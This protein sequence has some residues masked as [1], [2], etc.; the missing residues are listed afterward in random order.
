MKTNIAALMTFISEEEKNL[1][2][3]IYSIKSYIFNTTIQELDG[4]ENV[5]EDN[6]SNFDLL[7]NDIELITKKLSTLKS[8]LYDK[9]N[10]FKLSDG[11]TIQQAIVENTNLRKLKQCY[12]NL[13]EY[14]NTKKRVSEV[15]NSYFECKFINFNQDEIR[16]KLKELDLSIQNTDFEISKLNSKEFEINI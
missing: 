6:K 11:R 5:I 3:S 9:N 10:S 4:K 14:K 15:N 12:E 13:L 16:K 1:S 2:N 8:I 7:L